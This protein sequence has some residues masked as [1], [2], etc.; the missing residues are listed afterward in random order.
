MLL[1][2]TVLV[3][4][5]ELQS[6]P[7]N[8]TYAMDEHDPLFLLEPR[9]DRLPKSHESKQKMP[10]RRQHPLPMIVTKATRQ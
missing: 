8:E 3:E 5:F 4:T 2:S 6:D 7:A 10:I 9:V 1:F